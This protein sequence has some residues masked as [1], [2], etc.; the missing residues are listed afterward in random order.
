[1]E[2]AVFSYFFAIGSGLA[3]GVAV[4]GLVVYLIF[5]KMTGGRKHARLGQSK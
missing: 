5:R 2:G 1:M 3:S 4:V